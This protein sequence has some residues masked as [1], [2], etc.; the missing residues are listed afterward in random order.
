M[1]VK[2]RPLQQALQSLGIRAWFA[3]VM[4]D[5]LEGRDSLPYVRNRLGAIVVYPILDWRSTDAARYCREQDLPWNHDY[6]D[7]CKGWHQKLECGL[8][9]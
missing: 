4:H 8:H 6:W 5:K 3:G 7:P 2:V 9:G 1:K